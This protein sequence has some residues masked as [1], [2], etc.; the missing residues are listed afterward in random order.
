[1]GLPF[2]QKKKKK[3]LLQP[4]KTFWGLQGQ[5]LTCMNFFQNLTFSEVFFKTNLKFVVLCNLD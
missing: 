1:M 2:V 3:K 4:Q 5:F